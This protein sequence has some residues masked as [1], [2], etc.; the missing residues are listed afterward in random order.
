MRV[1]VHLAEGFEEIEAIAPIDILRRANCEVITVSISGNLKVT[2]AHNLPVIA[3]ILFENADYSTVQALILP[4]GMPGSK[5]LDQHQG[6]RNELLKA[7]EQGKLLAA[8]CA[9]PMVLGHL[10]LL[11]GKRATCY[12]GTDKELAGA[13][14]TGKPVETDGN[15]IT[16]NGP[17]ASMAFSYA[18]VE[19]IVSKN[20]AGELKTRMMYL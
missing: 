19:A 11:K 12:P 15:I 16:A 3:D 14:Y 17:G 13:T 1:F 7:N 18:I 6:L 5:N 2:G 8:N 9:A 20:M 4:G 10:G